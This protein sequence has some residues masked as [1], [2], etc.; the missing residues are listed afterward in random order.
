MSVH[1]PSFEMTGTWDRA[2]YIPDIS[3]SLMNYNTALLVPADNCDVIVAIRQSLVYMFLIHDISK[4]YFAHY[5]NA[6]SLSPFNLN[7]R[8]T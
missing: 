1:I 4:S 6:T 5:N 7:R 3:T 8:K 2:T